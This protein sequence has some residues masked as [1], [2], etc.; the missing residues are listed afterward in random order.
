MTALFWADASPSRMVGARTRRAAELRVLATAEAA[1]GG[2]RWANAVVRGGRGGCGR[3]GRRWSRSYWRLLAAR[4]RSCITL[5]PCVSPEQRYSHGNTYQTS[6]DHACCS[7]RLLTTVFLFSALGQ[8][9][10]RLLRK[11][12]RRKRKGWRGYL[13]SGRKPKIHRQNERA[14]FRLH[15]LQ[16]I[17]PEASWPRQDDSHHL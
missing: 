5:V 16:A 4:S 9:C 10:F 12:Q 7:Y 14:W 15:G 3:R 2:C 11:L 1:T 8:C 17:A 6:P 13:A